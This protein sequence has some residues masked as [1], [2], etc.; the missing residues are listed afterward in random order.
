ML[1][2]EFL[3][4]TPKLRTTKDKTIDKLDFIKTKIALQK[5]QKTKRQG[6]DWD[7]IFANHISEKQLIFRIYKEF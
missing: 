3:D 4:T 7:K 5:T 2:K 6:T 1:H